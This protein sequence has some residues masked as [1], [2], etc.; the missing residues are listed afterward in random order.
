M[1]R[2]VKKVTSTTLLMTLLGTL[3]VTNAAQATETAV[4]APHTTITSVGPGSQCHRL[5]AAEMQRATGAGWDDV[6]FLIDL[7]CVSGSVLSAV[8]AISPFVGAFCAGWAI[9]RFLGS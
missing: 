5:S 8:K 6:V 2:I 4:V 1:S 3:L 9:G 7:G